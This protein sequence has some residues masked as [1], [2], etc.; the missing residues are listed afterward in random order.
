MCVCVYVYI[1]IYIYTRCAHYR[2]RRAT[3]TTT[4]AVKTTPRYTTTSRWA[5]TVRN[6]RRQYG[7]RRLSCPPLV[8]PHRSS[9]S[10]RPAAYLFLVL[11]RC[12]AVSLRYACGSHAHVQRLSSFSRSLVLSIITSFSPALAHSYS[13]LCSVHLSSMHTYMRYLSLSPF[14]AIDDGAPVLSFSF[15]HVTSVAIHLSLPPP[16]DRESGRKSSPP[17]RVMCVRASRRAT[18]ADTFR[19][20]RRS[21]DQSARARST[22]PCE[23][24]RA[25]ARSRSALSPRTALRTRAHRR[26][27]EINIRSIVV[28]NISGGLC[29]TTR[30]YLSAGRVQQLSSRRVSR[31]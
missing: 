20:R 5:R 11:P 28:N 19:W 15:S 16:R 30:C 14:A 6:G 22:V 10:N 29:H 17:M 23:V 26:M 4:T 18:A 9:P 1:Y 27:G 13:W 24:V 31:R 3:A 25:N 8:L 12:V 21:V 2:R 7:A